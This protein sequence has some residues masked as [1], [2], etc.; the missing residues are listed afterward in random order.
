MKNTLKLA[1][2][3]LVIAQAFIAGHAEALNKK[4]LGD[5]VIRACSAYEP[6]YPHYYE[7]PDGKTYCCEELNPDSSPSGYGQ[8][9]VLFHNIYNT[10]D[11][12]IR[13]DFQL[14]FGQP[15]TPLGSD[16]SRITIIPGNN[17]YATVNWD[18]A[19]N[20]A[21]IGGDTVTI[22]YDDAHV[23]L[24]PNI[25]SPAP[26]AASVYTFHW[27]KDVSGAIVGWEFTDNLG[28]IDH[29]WDWQIGYY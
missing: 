17:G 1:A 23:A 11:P 16:E 9:C 29:G 10:I 3:A 14:G 25:A 2:A 24:H 27:T 12:G 26:G 8:G 15:N 20:G 4:S 19:L 28:H 6:N 21:T 18:I 22:A 7:A 5:P 13:I